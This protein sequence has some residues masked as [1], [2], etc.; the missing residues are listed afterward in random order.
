M[1]TKLARDL[2]VATRNLADAFEASLHA[3]DGEPLPTVDSVNVSE[4]P[5]FYDPERA[6]APFPP[7]VEGTRREQDLCI[8]IMFGRLYAINVR[9]GRGA[10]RGE[11]R[12]I[13]RAAGY[14]D[15]RAWGGWAKYATQRDSD[16]QVWVNETG[17]TDWIIKIAGRLNFTLPDELAV[18]QPPA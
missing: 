4:E 3:E 18:W 13:A 6:S 10:T 14:S 1:D 7:K 9:L 2:I 11:L 15:G 16:G 5:F 8:L 17:H 12:E